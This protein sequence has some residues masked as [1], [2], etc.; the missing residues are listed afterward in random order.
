MRRITDEDD[1]IVDE[2]QYG[3]WMAD[4]DDRI[5]S[6]DDVNRRRITKT[7]DFQYR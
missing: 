7:G 2:S 3:D 5:T 1:G 6:G 4:L